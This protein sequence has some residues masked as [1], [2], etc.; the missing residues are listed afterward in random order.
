MIDLFRIDKTE[1]FG[2]GLVNG[3]VTRSG[4]KDVFY[5]LVQRVYFSYMGDLFLTFGRTKEVQNVLLA[6]GSFL[7]TFNLK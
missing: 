7:S 6:F 2:L 4:D 3:E 5:L 1:G